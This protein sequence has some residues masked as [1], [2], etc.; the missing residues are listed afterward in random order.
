MLFMLIIS[1]ILN[2]SCFSFNL[3]CLYF[4][5]VLTFSMYLTKFLHCN[6]WVLE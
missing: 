4:L 3:E 5:V 2:F 6:N 1:Q